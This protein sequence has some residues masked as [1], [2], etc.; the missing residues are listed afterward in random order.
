MIKNYYKPKFKTMNTTELLPAKIGD[1]YEAESPVNYEQKCPLVLV[2]DVSSSMSGGPI[3]EL[4]KGLKVFQT[5]IQN[6]PVASQ[7]LETAIVTFGNGIEVPRDFSLFEGTGV[8]TLVANGH[9]P[10]VEAV[11]EAMA[12]IE[13][14]KAWYKEQGLQYYRPYIILM[15][16]GY[17]TSSRKEVEQLPNEIREGVE[18]RMFNFWAFGVERADMEFLQRISHQSFPPQKLKGQN[19]VEFFKWLSSSFSTITK[20]RN[21]EHADITP[22]ADANPFQITV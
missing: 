14:R 5:Q 20:S 11:R 17:P 16:D 6:D 12:R 1:F 19:F 15:T 3:D 22:K 4:N 8:E 21:G 7:R 2:L 18:N 10:L 13:A 9:T